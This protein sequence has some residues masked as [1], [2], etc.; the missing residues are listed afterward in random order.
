MD[1]G[2][3]SVCRPTYLLVYVQLPEDLGSVEEVLI[4]KDPITHRL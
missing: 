2:A 1:D 3:S 4:L